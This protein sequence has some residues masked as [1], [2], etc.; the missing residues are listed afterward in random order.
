MIRHVDGC[1]GCPREIGCIRGAC[2][3]EDEIE[4]ICDECGDYADELYDV[5]GSQLCASC[6]LKQFQKVEV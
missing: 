6:V 2:P 4:L 3:K 1:V 5:D